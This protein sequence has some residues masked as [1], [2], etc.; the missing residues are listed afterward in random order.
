MSTS[1]ARPG[2]TFW[3][4]AV[5]VLLTGASIAAVPLVKGLSK[6][7][8]ESSPNQAKEAMN[9]EL[10]AG[11]EDTLRLPANV[12]K[13]LNIQTAIAQ[14]APPPDPLELVGSL[15]LDTN[16]LARVHARFAGEVV[17][18]GQIMDS[19]GKSRR[20]Q[21]GDRVQEGQL[22]A[23][24]WSKDLGEK[25]SELIDALARQ[26]L[27]KETLARLEDL[28]QRGAVPERSLREAERNLEA[29]IIAVQRAERTLRSWRLS[30]AEL[31]ALRAEADSLRRSAGPPP[32][33]KERDWARVEVRAPFAGAILEMN[34]AVGDVVDTALDLFKIADLSRLK[35]LAHAYEEDLAKLQVLKSEDR[36]WLITLKSDPQSRPLE[37]VFDRIGDII[38]PNQRTALVIGTVQNPDG[39]LRVGQFITAR[40]PL[41]APAREVV[42]PRTA[43]YEDGQEAMV[44]VQ[45]NGKEP[46]FTCRKVA[47][48]S[49]SRDLMFVSAE[50]T[51]AEKRRGL[52]PLSPQEVVVSQGVVML[53]GK[54]EDLQAEAK[55][56]AAG[57]AAG[58]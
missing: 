34:L 32:P 26:R 3:T 44:F 55:A 5:G 1:I 9:A 42:V 23:V 36:R 50:L 41:P 21:L 38:D 13:A 17:E 46:E 28:Y 15:F 16:R 39:R 27:S 11:N 29:D 43:V 12:I 57:K 10:V 49:R 56:K 4:I 30:D 22:L 51:E 37:A 24:V 58:E 14:S 52:Q 45:A 7:N 33:N 19:S 54:L 20:V 47:I 53:A 6:R 8:A 31:G 35:V 40:I 48:R 18:I 25:K 2:K